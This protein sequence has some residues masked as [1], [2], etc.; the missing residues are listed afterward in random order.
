MSLLSSLTLSS[1]VVE[2]VAI[3]PAVQIFDA[4]S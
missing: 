3:P 1:G 4:K 2:K